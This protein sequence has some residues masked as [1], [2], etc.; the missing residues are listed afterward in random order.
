[1][2]RTRKGRG[3]VRALCE[4]VGAE[5]RIE[6]AVGRCTGYVESCDVTERMEE[7]WHDDVE[8]IDCMVRYGGYGSVLANLAGARRA[9]CGGAG[10]VAEVDVRIL[11]CHN[12]SIH[13]GK[14]RCDDIRVTGSENGVCEYSLNARE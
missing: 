13:E 6:Y 5:G 3:I 2:V 1:M 7:G 8:S 12:I 4:I 10:G 14:R 11:D 9:G